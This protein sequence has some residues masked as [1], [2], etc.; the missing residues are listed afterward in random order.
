MKVLSIVLSQVLLAAP[1][2]GIFFNDNGPATT[3]FGPPPAGAGPDIGLPPGAGVLGPVLADSDFD[4]D[5]EIL[6]FQNGEYYVGGA[7]PAAGQPL[8][9]EGLENLGGPVGSNRAFGYAGEGCATIDFSSFAVD[10]VVIQAR[11]TDSA[12]SVGGTAPGT[13]FPNST[14]FDDADVTLTVNS[15]IFGIEF[16]FLPRLTAS[17]SNTAYGTY[18]FDAPFFGLF[19]SLGSVEIC[20]ANG[21]NSAAL[22]GEFTVNT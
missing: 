7:A 22:I 4:F 15:S 16:F 2:N 1:A 12:D 8:S 5:G 6:F 21:G 11:G 3:V 17:V 10:S 19:T 20:N 13:T 14:P 18:R 9:P